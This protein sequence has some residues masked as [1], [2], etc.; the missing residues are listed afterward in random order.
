[1]ITSAHFVAEVLRAPYLR[2]VDDFA[3]FNKD[4]TVLSEGRLHRGAL[5]GPRDR[6]HDQREG[7]RRRHRRIE[8]DIF[9]RPDSYGTGSVFNCKR[10]GLESKVCP[11]SSSGHVDGTN[12]FDVEL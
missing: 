1:M 3:L 8:K 4:P 2:Y 5:P 6:G 9:L 11:P 7:R 10:L 12:H